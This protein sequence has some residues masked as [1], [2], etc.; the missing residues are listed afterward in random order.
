LSE[1]IDAFPMHLTSPANIA[2]GI[3]PF[4]SD[5]VKIRLAPDHVGRRVVLAG[6]GYSVMREGYAVAAGPGIEDNREN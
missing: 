6:R 3:V 4:S 5:T 2:S 1:P